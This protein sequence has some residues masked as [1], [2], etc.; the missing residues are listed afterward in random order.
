MADAS[1]GIFMALFYKLRNEQKLNKAKALRK[2]QLMFIS[3]AQG[4]DV[5]ARENRGVAAA[6]EDEGGFTPSPEAPY[7]HPFYWAPFI[8]MGNYL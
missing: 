8:L 2:V 7:A 6:D 4:A 1:T 3:G 5:H